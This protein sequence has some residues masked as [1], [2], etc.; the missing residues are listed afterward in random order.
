MMIKDINVHF[1]L[2][3]E[4]SEIRKQITFG[5]DERVAFCYE[6]C[7]NSEMGAAA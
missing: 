6:H 3:Y 7:F 5:P 1:H 4:G 2:V